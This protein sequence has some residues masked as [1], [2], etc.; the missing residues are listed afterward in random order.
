[1]VGTLGVVDA[2]ASCTGAGFSEDPSACQRRFGGRAL[3]EWVTRRLSESQRLDAVAVI[4]PMAM[5]SKLQLPPDI[6]VLGTDSADPVARLAEVALRWHP[7]GMVRVA[8]G[9]PFVDP[10]LIDRLIAAAEQPGDKDACDYAG[11]VSSDCP[12]VREAQVG[13]AADWF[14]TEAV[15]RLAELTKGETTSPAF[16]V[17]Q[18]SDEFVMRLLPLPPELDRADMRLALNV[19]DDW[20]HARA[21]YEALGP[22]RLEWRRITGLL[23]GQPAMRGRMADLNRRQEL[24]RT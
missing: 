12:G 22:D 18:R 10:L 13:V 6:F 5:L 23:E 14:S 16:R 4:V 21:I 24:A 3:W 1:M 7:K 15:L 20:E 2:V 19:E 8:A 11:F 17:L 9:Q